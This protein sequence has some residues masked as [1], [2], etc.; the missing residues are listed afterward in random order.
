MEKEEVKEKKKNKKVL[1]IVIVLFVILAFII[2]F[3]LFQLLKPKT[4]KFD[5]GNGQTE[6]II[7]KDGEQIKFPDP[8]VKE[9]YDFS[10]WAN[11]KG[12]YVLDISEINEKEVYT[13]V[14][15]DKKK[16]IYILTFKSDDVV[17]GT[18][19]LEEGKTLTEPIRPTKDGYIF[20]GWLNE[21]GNLI[22]YENS[23]TRDC[24]FTAYWISNKADYIEV[25][26]DTDGGNEIE[27][28]K[29]EKGKTLVLPVNPK[30]TGYVFGGW[31]DE[32]GNSITNKTVASRD[33]KLK[34]IWKDPY[35]CPENCTPVGDGSTCTRVDY[36]DKTNYSNCPSGYSM[37]EGR[38]IDAG[39]SFSA[40][41]EENNSSGVCPSGY[42]TYTE[43]S[44]LGAD[45]RCGKEVQKVTGERCPDGYSDNGSNCKKEET[46]N[47]QAN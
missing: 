47:C 2:V 22:N 25:S 32:N 35:T 12:E 3:L 18:F 24:T 10:G 29:V 20:M 44:G 14:Y 37:I 45:L 1:I 26:F 9:G 40:F 6:E 27:P 5:L 30:K 7:I 42:Y 11:Q 36:A 23:I 15:V 41:G 17:I 33:F 39:N 28:I 21:D 43:V 46:I 8:P 31:V 19:K 16:K 38:C 13:P 34:A 4:I